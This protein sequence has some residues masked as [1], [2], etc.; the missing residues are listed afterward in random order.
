MKFY[1][2]IKFSSTINSILILNKSINH[3]KFLSNIL[4][5][6]SEN[7]TELSL[8]FNN[9]NNNY[10]SGFYNNVHTNPYEMLHYF[11]NLRKLNI[12]FNK[13]LFDNF[14][15]RHKDINTDKKI[16]LFLYFGFFSNFLQNFIF[17]WYFVSKKIK[18]YLHT[19]Q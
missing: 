18:C 8:F 17:F 5:V 6:N 12:D 4:C 15:K 7:I 3:H 13:V 9:N 10:I 19:Q 16:F 1:K 11:K 2:E 14:K